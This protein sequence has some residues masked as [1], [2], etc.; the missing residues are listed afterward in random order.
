MA[1]MTA[2]SNKDAFSLLIGDFAFLFLSLWVALLVRYGGA[3][4][5]GASYAVHLKSFIFV[6]VA[7]LIVFYVAGLYEKKIM[8]RR[9][10]LPVIIFQSQLV[11]TALA[12]AFFYFLPYVDIAPKTNLFIYLGVSLLFL[13]FWRMYLAPMIG[14]GGTVERAVIVGEGIE[15]DSI[16]KELNNHRV[17][18]TTV[19]GTV[20]VSRGDVR[21][22]SLIIREYVARQ[23]VSV[24]IIDTTHEKCAPLFS[25]LY[26]LF[27]S[28]V[29]FIDLTTLYEDLFYRIPV[30]RISYGWCLANISVAP[31]VTYDVL[32]RIMDI[33]IS[34]PLAAGSLV[35]YPFIILLIKLDDRGSV[36]ISQERIGKNDTLVRTSKFRSMTGNDAGEY[37]SDGLT[38][39]TVTRAGRFLRRTRL[40]E[41]PQLWAVVAGKLSLVGPRPELP[42]VVKKYE[43]EIPY[44]AI[45]HLIKPGLSGWAQIYGEHAHHG[46]DLDKTKDKL[47]YDLYYI[48]NR[49][50]LLDLKIALKTIKLLL[51]RKG[52]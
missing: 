24:I 19:S 41:L 30:T 47:S 35:L 11:N 42:S 36:F 10:E 38:N 22:Q 52:I 1:S 12:M 8:L 26:D 6:F 9:G 17:Y 46:V 29:R 48:K 3:I 25:E 49:S 31:K 51:S 45:R 16:T 13:V 32:K 5:E 23:N 20:D 28:H 15:M 14:G 39:L 40:D 34:L 43:K 27:L 21:E 33:V 37:G 44:F 18:R 50:F 2:V 4:P 7:S